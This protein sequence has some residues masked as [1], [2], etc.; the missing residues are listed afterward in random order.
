MKIIILNPGSRTGEHVSRDVL[1]GCW[2]K[3]KKAGFTEYPP[4]P[5]LY[6]NTVLKNDGFE[7]EFLDAQGR[8]LDHKRT[9]NSIDWRNIDIVI[10]Q[11]ATMTFLEDVDLFNSIKQENPNIKTIIL[12]SHV[13]FM[14]DSSLK[15][16]SIDYIIKYEPEDSVLNLVKCL[17]DNGD[18]INVKGI[19]FKNRDGEVIVTPDAPF[20]DFDSLPIPNREYIRDIKYYNPLVK[21][22][23]WTTIETTRGCPARCVFCT[24][25]T[26]FGKKVRKRSVDKV[27]DELRYLE[28]MGY[29]EAFFR[30]ET[31][32]YHRKRVEE[33]CKGILKEKMDLTWI[34]NA[35][36]GTVD[37][38]LMK[39]MMEAGCHQIKFGV[40]S[41]VQKILNNL[42]KGTS[43]EM[44]RQTFRWANEVGL[45]THA[46]F[47]LG[48]PG[49]TK[50]TI[51]DTINF[52]ID[53]EPTT[54]SFG[55]LTP[56]PGTELFDMMK[57]KLPKGWDGTEAEIS[58]LHTQSFYNEIFCEV[59]R[60]DLEEYMTLAYR[61]FYMRPKYILKKLA[62]IRS[63]NQLRANIKSGIGT[64]S[65]A[66]TKSS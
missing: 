43:V 17:D 3:G 53:V 49:D 19:G 2:C 4:L 15:K 24:A 35:R 64:I 54:V 45:D 11:T 16:D 29:K 38:E 44:A 63:L 9:L 41:G 21:R 18:P 32:T 33:I 59:S 56:Y 61:K 48:C 5:L 47:M 46:H 12:G 58:R 40:E 57:D 22:P 6:V 52:A 60:D 20:V 37:K 1:Y 55:I 13:S 62:H 28:S 51:L 65:Y 30:D 42:N 25:P 26:F 36:I 50:K 14:P 8:G 10:S 23:P 34:C 31:F 39:T 66:I 27:I 7:T